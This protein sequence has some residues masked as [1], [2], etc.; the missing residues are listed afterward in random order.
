MSHAT[1][2]WTI[3]FE[4][5]AYGVLLGWILAKQRRQKA[6]RP[7]TR[8][9]PRTTLVLNADAGRWISAGSPLELTFNGSTEK[10]VVT[11]TVAPNDRI[12]SVVRAGATQ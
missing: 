1:L 9:P 3:V 2:I 6:R 12:I 4:W 5:A 11:S 7:A 8:Q 10:Y